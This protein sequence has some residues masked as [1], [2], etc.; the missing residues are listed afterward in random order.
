MNN[1]LQRLAVSCI[2]LGVLVPGGDAQS[3]LVTDTS[4]FQGFSV[5][6]DSAVWGTL[7]SAREVDSFTQTQPVV[8]FGS[9]SFFLDPNLRVSSD[10]SAGPSSLTIQGQIVLDAKPGWGLYSAGFTQSGQWAI[11]G[12]GA[13]SVDG[14]FIDI[15]ATNGQFFYTDQRAFTN[16]LTQGGDAQNG[17][18]YIIGER[19]SLSRYGQ[20]I[21]DY[22]IRLSALAANQPGSAQL[23]SDASDPSF[24]NRP[25]PYPDSNVVGTFVSVSYE[26]VAPVPVPASLPLLF[27]GLAA[28]SF[29]RR[30]RA[31]RG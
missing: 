6:Y 25:G 4:T 14:S 30:R 16:P 3:A 7:L 21:I 31:K 19:S 26:R 8:Q 2:V 29:L 27:S 24:L 13:V 9:G 5:T 17:Y 22:D 23:F 10:G 18:Y 15:S 1:S 12:T 20:L 11:T 28:L